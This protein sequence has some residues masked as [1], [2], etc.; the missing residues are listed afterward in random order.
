MVRRGTI[1]ETKTN[2]IYTHSVHA[3]DLAD[4]KGGATQLDGCVVRH[5]L[6][7]K[8]ESGRKREKTQDKKLKVLFYGAGEGFKGEARPSRTISQQNSA[9]QGPGTRSQ[10]HSS[11]DPDHI[12]HQS[13]SCSDSGAMWKGSGLRLS[14]GCGVLAIW[15]IRFEASANEL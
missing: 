9:S 11:K 1:R 8:G 6:L 14:D 5:Q 12:I 15:I 2:P 4:Q 10:L 13:Q 3:G 7:E